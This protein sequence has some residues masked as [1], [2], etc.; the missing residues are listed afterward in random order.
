LRPRWRKTTTGI[1][2]TIPH[3]HGAN[4]AS[5]NT[6]ASIGV[7]GTITIDIMVG[8][9]ATRR[10]GMATMCLRDKQRNIA[11]TITIDGLASAGVTTARRMHVD[12]L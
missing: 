6:V 12:R 2:I 3:E 11:T 7:N 5:G 8:I 10:D 9:E 1:A 4:I